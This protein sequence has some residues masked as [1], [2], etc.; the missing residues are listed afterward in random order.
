MS[1]DNDSRNPLPV[2]VGEI[3]CGDALR[4]ILNGRRQSFNAVVNLVAD[5]YLGI[6][7]R[8]KLAPMQDYHAQLYCNVLQEAGRVLTARE[9]ATFPSMVED[10][11]ARHPEFPQGPGSTALMIVKASGYVDLVALIDEMERLP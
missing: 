10:W 4:T 2:G 7:G 1:I 3:E 8:A 9:I 6:V 5:R 11:L